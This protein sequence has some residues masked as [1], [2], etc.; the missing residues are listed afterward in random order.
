[1]RIGLSPDYFR[2]TFPDG[3][4]G[5]TV[6]PDGS[7]AA[8]PVTISDQSF[9]FRSLRANVV[10]RW[11]YR[12][13]ATLFVVWQQGRAQT[14][15][16][17]GTFEFSRDYRDLFRAHPINTLLVKVGEGKVLWPYYMDT[18]SKLDASAATPTARGDTRGC[19]SGRNCN[20]RC[21]SGPN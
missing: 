19:P 15:I 4:G 17:P 14:E 11:E 7:G 10:L 2:I 5:F 8:A 3:N 21:D 12:P 6:D 16:N 9:N 13:G 18:K 20:R 1:M